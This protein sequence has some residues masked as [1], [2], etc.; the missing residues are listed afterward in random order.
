MSRRIALHCPECRMVSYRPAGFVRAKSYF[1]C[2]YCHEIIK[3]D[4]H[5]RALALNRDQPV[6]HVKADALEVVSGKH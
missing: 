2:N 3:I 4:R 6:V 1:V 5:Q